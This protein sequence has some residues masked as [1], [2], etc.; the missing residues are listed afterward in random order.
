MTRQRIT[1]ITTS[2][3]AGRR[4]Q[5]YEDLAKS[6]LTY[7]TF[8]IELRAASLKDILRSKRASNRPQDQQDVIYPHRDAEAPVVTKPS[9]GERCLCG[10]PRDAHQHPKQDRH[11]R[12][13]QHAGCPNQDQPPDATWPGDWPY[14]H[15]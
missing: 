5:G 12:K 1:V 3:S 11:E 14:G 13:H 8:G 15:Q 7:Q 2:S 6:A 10:Q 9:H 4:T